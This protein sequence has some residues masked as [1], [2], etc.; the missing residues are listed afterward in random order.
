MSESNIIQTTYP[1]ICLAID[2]CFASKRFTEPA[3]WMRLGET[4]D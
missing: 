2:N 1:E 4:D 3:E